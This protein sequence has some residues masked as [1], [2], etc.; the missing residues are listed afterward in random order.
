MIRTRTWTTLAG[1]AVL[2]LGATPA[3][4]QDDAEM[5]DAEMSMDDMTISV[6]GVEYAFTGLPETVPAGTTLTFTNEGIELHEIIVNRIPDD[7]EETFEELMALSESGVDLEAEGYIDTDFGDQM[8]LAM[9]GEAAEGGIALEQ[10]GRYVA[11]CGI[12]TGLEPGK[13][14]D[15]GV[16]ISTIGPET[17]MEELPAEAQA[18]L[19][20]VMSTGVPHLFNGMIQEFAV[21]AEGEEMDEAA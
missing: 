20:E 15:F 14:A 2:A 6:A 8:L 9:P 4:A 10:E 19:E 12:P 11:L 3:F 16:D 18:Y 5:T 21:V 7:V 13:L 1:A 17:D